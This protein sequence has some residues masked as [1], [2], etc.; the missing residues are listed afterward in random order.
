ME[1]NNQE[2]SSQQSRKEPAL[3]LST[4]KEKVKNEFYLNPHRMVIRRQKLSSYDLQALTTFAER[5][6]LDVT[7]SVSRW[8][9]QQ[10]LGINEV[11]DDAV[12]ISISERF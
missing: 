10:R 5:F 3:D 9:G 7:A 6:G 11:G 8:D 1:T 2:V 12:L 4:L